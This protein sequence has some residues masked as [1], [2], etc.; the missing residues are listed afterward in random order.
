MK[1]T[2]VT[3]QVG[4]GSRGFSL[5]E[6]ILT[7]AVLGICLAIVLPNIQRGL[8]EREVR[9]SA[10]GLAAAA[11]DLRSRAMSVGVMQELVLDLPDHRYLAA[12]SAEVRLPPDVRFIAVD[13]GESLDRDLKRFYFFPNG[14]A[15]GGEIV[16]AD[17][18]GSTP[19]LVRFEPLTGRVSVA[20]AD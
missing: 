18:G 11:R 20:R 17:S 7:L 9:T 2:T 3:L 5:F 16:L 13:G 6:L 14:S 4:K 1:T 15:L 8:Q 12:R 10:L 19:Y